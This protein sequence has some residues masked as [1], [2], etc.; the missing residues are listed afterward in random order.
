MMTVHVCNACGKDNQANARF[1]NWCG[2]AMNGTS[3]TG[4]LLTQ[5]LLHNGR[6][7]ILERVGK[8]GMAAVYKAQ[9]VLLN[10][11]VVAIKEMS[12][13]GL[14]GQDLQDAITAFTHEANMLVHL[15]HQSLPHIYEQFEDGGRRYLVME[16][17]QGETLEDRLEALRLQGKRLAIAQVLDIAR[18]LC[19][20]LDYLHSQQPPVIFRDLKPSNIMLTGQGQVYLIDFGIARLFKP[21]QAKDT[22]ALGS[23]GYAPPEQ[24]RKTTSP[25]SDIYSLGATLHQMLTGDDPS[26]NPFHFRSFVVNMPQLEQLV[27]CMIALDEH[28]RPASMKVV[29]DVLDNLAQQRQPKQTKAHKHVTG[30]S[31]HVGSA[32]PKGNNSPAGSAVVNMPTP[33]TVCVVI[34]SHAADQL[35]WR[36]IHSQLISLIDGFPHIQ[37][38]TDVQCLD[39]ANLILLL[40]SNDFLTSPPCMTA[41]SRAVDRDETQGANVLLVLLRQCSLAGSRLTHLRTIPDDAV[42]HLS[43]YAQEQRI[44]EVARTIRTHLVTQLLTGKSSGPMNLLQWLLW[45]L[46][47]NG[48]ATC[49]YFLVGRYALKHVRP[50]GLASILLHLLDLQKG[51]MTAEYLVG[52]V[53][54]RDLSHL[55]HVVAPSVVDPAAVQGIATRQKPQC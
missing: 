21:G 1:C 43:L 53:R 52:P 44:L 50:A 11:R 18:Q 37:I 51:R 25:R 2:T 12:Q 17:L 15:K 23:P 24:Y 47:G 54:C 31:R 36:D 7:L 3:L 29:L 33:L 40:L 10:Q 48:H 42:A 30:R 46:Y 8:G 13:N 9:D 19:V 28:Q 45:Q 26:Q 39:T 16:F 27:L 35:L 38:K 20:V 34:S 55:L 32:T 22:I 49:R 14:T 41:A 6:Y 5:S 4:L